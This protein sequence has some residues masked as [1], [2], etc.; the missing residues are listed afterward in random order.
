MEAG[1]DD[2]S[3]EDGEDDEPGELNGS[4]ANQ[5]PPEGPEINVKPIDVGGPGDPGDDD[6]DI[7]AFDKHPI[8]LNIYLR[9]WVLY[10]FSNATHDTIQSTLKSHQLALLAAAQIANFPADLIAW[11]KNMPLTLRALEHRIG[12]DF[13]E[14]ITTY[15]ICP[16]ETCGKR[17]TFEELA[18][19]LDRQCMRHIT[20]P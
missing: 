18:A 13:S 11:I 6:D 20:E 2:Q 8:L 16:V 17:Y 14:S 19:L 15:P 4:G 12:M 5:L 3:G 7:V 9:T 1:E 10:T